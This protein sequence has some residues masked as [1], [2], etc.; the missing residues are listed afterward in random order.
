MSLNILPA[1]IKQ[2]IFSYLNVTDLLNICAVCKDFN[3]F[4]GQSDVM[5]KIWIKFYTF[6]MKDLE[7]LASSS[8]SYEKLKVNRVNSSEHFKFLTDL[9]QSWKK[10][11]IYNCEFKQIESFCQF[12]ES[13]SHSV[14][15]L[16]VS[17]IEILDNNHG[18]CPLKFPSLK[19][20]MFRNV[21]SKIIEL[22]LGYNKNLES[23][24]FDIVQVMEG[25][26]PLDQIVHSFLEYNKKLKHCSFGPHYIKSFFDRENV[27][28][29]FDFNLEKLMLKFPIIRDESLKIEENV[30][31]FL[32]NQQKIDWLLFLELQNEAILCTAWNDLRSVDHLTFVGLEGLFDEDM[33]LAMMPNLNITHIELLSRKILL[34]QLR[35][36]FLAAPNLMSLH[37]HSLTKYIMEFTA[38]NHQNIRQ[39]SYETFD[40][41]AFEIYNQLKASSDDVNKKIELKKRNFW[42]DVAEPTFSL[43]PIFWHV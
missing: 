28:M 20:I 24:S 4:L 8:R 7:S 10:I 36:I 19:R 37:V 33:D 35:K 16:E 14:M 42:R 40:E 21:P 2:I 26:M 18:V 17:D 5:K 41:E 25:N 9:D 15:E 43:D 1:E 31:T 34:S 12:V 39:M 3:D 32:K 29:K 38:R 13:F 6:K 22:F 11:L 23:A 30:C 27:E